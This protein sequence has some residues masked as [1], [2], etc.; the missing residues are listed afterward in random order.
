MDLPLSIAESA[1]IMAAAVS[2]MLEFVPGPQD[3]ATGSV[4]VNV[5]SGK[6]WFKT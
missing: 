3:M 1:G 5:D 2:L 6:T 4:M